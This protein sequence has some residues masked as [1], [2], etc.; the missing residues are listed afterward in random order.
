MANRN[1]K[2]K[3]KDMKTDWMRVYFLCLATLLIVTVGCGRGENQANTDH[4]LYE[5]KVYGPGEAAG[6]PGAI[7]TNGEGTTIEILDVQVKPY[8]FAD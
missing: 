5:H 3:G 7:I 6:H 2:P 8:R 1:H 4:P